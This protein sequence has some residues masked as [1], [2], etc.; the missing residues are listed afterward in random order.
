VEHVEVRRPAGRPLETMEQ[1]AHLEQGRI[2]GLSVE[3]DEGT[4]RAQRIADGGQQLALVAEARAGTAA[5]R[6]RHRLP[7]RPQP[8]RNA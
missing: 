1:V 3:A 2:E 8:T 6:T 5:S 7:H 4:R